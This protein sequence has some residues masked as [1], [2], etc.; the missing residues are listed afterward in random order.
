VSKC[1]DGVAVA[2]KKESSSV[3]GFS[4]SLSNNFL[5]KKKALVRIQLWA[6]I[7]IE[8]KRLRYL[9]VTQYGAGSTPVSPANEIKRMLSA[10]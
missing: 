6:L 8:V 10:N 2:L 4:K 3:D 5:W 9:P 7:G 1:P